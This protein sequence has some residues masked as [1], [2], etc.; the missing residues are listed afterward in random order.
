MA[1]RMLSLIPSIPYPVEAEGRWLPVTS[2]IDWCE[3]NYYATT[4]SA[5]IVNTLTNL[6]FMY[7][8]AKGIHNVLTQG[9]DGVFLV[10]FVG[11]L[12]VGIGSFLFHS[13]LKYPFQLVDELSMIYTT[14]LM[15]FATFS[16]GGSRRYRNTLAASLVLLSL[17]I[18]IYYHYLQD[19]T[20]HEVVYAI[21]TVIVVVR[22]LF[23]METNLRPRW[24]S[25]AREAANPRLRGQGPAAVM[26]E[27]ERD[28]KILREMWIMFFWGVSIFLS[29]FALWAVDNISCSSLV[30][31]RR[32]IG[33]PWGVL[34]ELHG[35]WHLMTGVGAYAYLV[36]GIWLRHCL[37]Y[38][39]DEYE[40]VWP[41]WTSMPV[42]L[43]RQP[44]Y[45]I[46]GTDEKLKELVRN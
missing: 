8:A 3:E 28:Q 9:H 2:T 18:T 36:W 33:L 1:A 22:S 13:T 19:P 43:K 35:W 14:C 45:Q 27:N 7:L 37:D 5:E 11:Y 23:L 24:R 10:G 46:N 12:L 4:Y 26:I 30:S 41:R 15:C 39:Q 20:F 32:K 16:Y 17:F 21:L 29:G 6:L 34:L 38:K 31:L 40:L 44:K 25:K 42:V